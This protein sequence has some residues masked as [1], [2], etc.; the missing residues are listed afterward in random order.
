[1]AARRRA[2][3]ATVNANAAEI[4]P[5]RC[6][7]STPQSGW[8]KLAG[9]RHD[10][11]GALQR[12]PRWKVRRRAALQHFEFTHQRQGTDEA[13]SGPLVN[14]DSWHWPRDTQLRED[15]HRY[16]ETNCVQIMATLPSL[17]MK[18]LQ[19]DDFWSSTEALAALS[20]DIRVY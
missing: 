1:M 19:H 8:W 18:A 4:S 10:P 17:T 5:G 13:R 12:H 11:G 6:G 7:A 3:P 15:A 14:R 9:L 16:C 20:H 2:K